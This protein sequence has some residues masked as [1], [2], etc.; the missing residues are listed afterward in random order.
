MPMVNS[1]ISLTLY[2]AVSSTEEVRR[3]EQLADDSTEAS[4]LQRTTTW[5]SA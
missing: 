4:S 3:V 2:I 1:S 5:R